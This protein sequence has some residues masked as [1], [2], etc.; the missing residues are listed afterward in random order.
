MVE[1]LRILGSRLWLK[2]SFDHDD[3]P[4]VG[5]WAI[6]T[7]PSELEA[8]VG[9]SPGIG[10]IFSRHLVTELLG[11]REIQTPSLGSSASHLRCQSH[12]QRP[13][14]L[15][16]SAGPNK[17]EGFRPLPDVLSGQPHVFPMTDDEGKGLHMNL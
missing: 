9:G 13:I 4:P 8:V 7:R 6:T 10:T 2:Q 17:A 14:F 12:S 15:E 11:T 5:R 16:S 1:P 3:Q